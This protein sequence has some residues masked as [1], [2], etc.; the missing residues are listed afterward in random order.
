MKSNKC[1]REV[2]NRVVIITNALHYYRTPISKHNNSL[3]HHN[4]KQGKMSIADDKDEMKTEIPLSPASA[5][6]S[7]NPVPSPIATVAA[8]PPRINDQKVIDETQ[9]QGSDEKDVD[10]LL[11]DLEQAEPSEAEIAVSKLKE[12]TFKLTSAL[13]TV[14]SDID[15]KY[16]IVDQARSVDSQLGVSKTV[17]SATTSIGNLWG[18]MRFGE[19]AMG[20]MNQ[21]AVKNV[22]SSLNN[23]FEKTGIKNV[24]GR[25]VREVQTLDDQHKVSVQAVGALNS[26]IDWM[27]NT[28]QSSTSREKAQPKDDFHDDEWE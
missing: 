5:V 2:E 26:G 11:D 3:L 28:L 16:N 20:I 10:S 17:V 22:S 21:D 12:S 6:P 15:S 14:G 27:A 24:V 19:K 7:T 1:S 9:E 25:G 23:T 4:T 13:K 8:T 18:S